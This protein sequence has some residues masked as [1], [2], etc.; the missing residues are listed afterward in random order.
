MGITSAFLTADP[1]AQRVSRHD[2][3]FYCTMAVVMGLAVF[4]GFARTYYLR[5]FSGGPTVTIAG[6]PF[7]PVVHIHGA[8]FT[9]WVLLFIV[10]TALVAQR[11]VALHRTL[12]VAGAALAAAMVMSGTTI[13][14]WEARLQEGLDI[15]ASPLLLI[16]RMSD[17]LIFTTF[18]IAAM[19]LRRNKEA[20]KRLMV[21]AYVSI[22]N[23]AIARIPGMPSR[24]TNYALTLL[25][26]VAGMTYDFASRRQVHQVYLWGGTLFAIILA[27]QKFFL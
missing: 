18:V 10:Q 15:T 25:F 24:F 2:R 16:W 23:A 13:R 27:M 26:V 9:T 5:L 14:I 17:M 19:A 21:L 4:A 8:I 3:I 20:H 22:L 1:S 12:G 7:A 11:R 6:L